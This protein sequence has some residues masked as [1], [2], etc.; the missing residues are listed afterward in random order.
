MD[1]AL[2]EQACYYSFQYPGYHGPPPNAIPLSHIPATPIPPAHFYQPYLASTPC[3]Y[4]TVTFV[5][6]ETESECVF[7]LSKETDS[8]CCSNLSPKMMEILQISKYLI[9]SDRLDFMDGRLATEE[10]CS[11]LDV[12]TAFLEDMISSGRLDELN[13]I[14]ESQST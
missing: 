9:H 7:S 1:S 3:A 12:D 11:V 6:L 5:T 4:N 13:S 14:I 10:E 8:H 2:Q